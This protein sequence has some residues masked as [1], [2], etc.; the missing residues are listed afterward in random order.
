MEASKIF[1]SARTLQN[2]VITLLISKDKKSHR[3][4][5]YILF[6]IFKVL[7]SKE[8]NWLAAGRD[9]NFNLRV[10]KGTIKL[11]ERG[12]WWLKTCHIYKPR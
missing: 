4:D 1:F 9:G 11:R 3:R 10:S 2:K 8:G 6:K 12:C 5:I 7:T